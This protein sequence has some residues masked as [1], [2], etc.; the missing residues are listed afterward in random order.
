MWNGKYV[1][2][3]YVISI[4]EIFSPFC[5]EGWHLNNRS[6][7]EIHSFDADAVF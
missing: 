6:H 5:T 7:G 2:N 4:L 1:P 3:D